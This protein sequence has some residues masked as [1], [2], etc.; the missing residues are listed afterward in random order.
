ML[1]LKVSMIA[2]E[3]LFSLLNLGDGREAKGS[4]VAAGD[5]HDAAAKASKAGAE[6]GKTAKSEVAKAA[7][8]VANSEGYQLIQWSW[9]R[10]GH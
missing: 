7:T 5:H 6:Y 10:S 2:A 3:V 9:L 4:K 8:K 1:Q